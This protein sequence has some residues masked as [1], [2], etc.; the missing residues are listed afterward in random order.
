MKAPA[1]S[2]AAAK[3]FTLIELL[4]VIAIIGLLAS[5]ILASLGGARQK[6]RDARRIADIREIQNALELYVETCKQYP[7]PSPLATTD[8]N[9]CSGGVNLGTFLPT[10]PKDPSSSS[11]NYPYTA[12]GSLGSC[13]SYHLAAILEA[14]PSNAAATC[15][16]NRGYCTGG[17]YAG[18]YGN[19]SGD[20]LSS[21]AGDFDESGT[22]C[23]AVLTHGSYVY[24][25]GP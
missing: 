14:K 16:A 15:L 7:E 1:R 3:G 9:G 5:I 13:T 22:N 11:T 2:Q 4:V 12:N 23:G 6:A 25:V 19:G 17:N 20:T 24:D 18:G 10:I 21:T 8:S